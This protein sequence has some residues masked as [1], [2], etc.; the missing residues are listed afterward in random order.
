[1]TDEVKKFRNWVGTHY[2]EVAA[3]LTDDQFRKAEQFVPREHLPVGFEYPSSYKDFVRQ[4]PVQ[5]ENL[6][7]WGYPCDLADM[8]TKYSKQPTANYNKEINA[9]LVVFAQA[10]G[11]DMIAAF[12]GVPSPNP[13]VLVL[14]PWV[15]KDP[16][17]TALIEEFENFDAWHEWARVEEIARKAEM[18][19]PSKK[20]Q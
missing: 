3:K 20:Y 6:G 9:P 12:E 18:I 16:Y 8:S 19:L 11:E 7:S 5:M 4:H 14:N 15:G 2:P 17:M 13:R 10:F 1:M